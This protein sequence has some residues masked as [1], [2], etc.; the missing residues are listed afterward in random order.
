MKEMLEERRK[1]LENV[2]F[3]KYNRELLEQMRENRQYE[4]D[5]DR[6]SKVCGIED[7]EFLDLLLDQDIRAESLAALILVPL[8]VVAWADREMN[9]EEI[10]VILEAAKELGIEEESQAIKLLN[11]WLVHPPTGKLIDAWT[12]YTGVLCDRLND[13]DR[14]HFGDNILH[15]ANQVARAAGGVLGIGP[16]ICKKEREAL[17]R[18]AAVFRV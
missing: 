9:R 8:V 7:E 13:D 17:D 18:M 6:L 2:F 1:A 14:K 12:E 11:Y 16:K 10:R 5:R 3:E 4:V 15:W